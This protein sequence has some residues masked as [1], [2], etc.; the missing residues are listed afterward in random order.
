[1]AEVP[2]TEK[3]KLYMRETLSE[4]YWQAD[5]MLCYGRL[6]FDTSASLDDG[7]NAKGAQLARFNWNRSISTYLSKQMKKR[8]VDL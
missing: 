5:Q 7:I 1:M 8:M 3:G 4:Q 2:L 6:H